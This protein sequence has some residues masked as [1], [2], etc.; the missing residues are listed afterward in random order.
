[1]P[2]ATLKNAPDANGLPEFVLTPSP[3]RR[4]IM[5]AAHAGG[6]IELKVPS[7]FTRKQGEE[8]LRTHSAL[9]RR[10]LRRAAGIPR[11]RYRE[12]ET[13]F[14]LGKPC[15]IRFS[16]RLR[17]IDD[18]VLLVPRGDEESVKASLAA[19]YRRLAQQILPDR[20]RRLDRFH[21]TTERPVRI[22][23]ATTRWGSCSTS[24]MIS[25][26]WRLVQCSPELIDY[27]ILHE[28]THLDE[29]NHSARF[30][31]L[32][33]SRCPGAKELRS[34]LRFYARRSI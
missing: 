19:L 28:L 6:I 26:S 11:L 10:L 20:V 17:R 16:E 13:F 2:D 27:V 9:V 8:L 15:T 24:G 4:R 22:S 21:G 31:R 1:M 33:E 30:W 23:S 7:G 14:C 32:L 34:R 5:I 12:G 25:L 3:R 18:G 29:M